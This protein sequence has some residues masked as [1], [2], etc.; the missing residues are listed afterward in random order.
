MFLKIEFL[1]RN[2]SKRYIY[3]KKYD[4]QLPKLKKKL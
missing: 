2:F 4:M 3:V 1:V